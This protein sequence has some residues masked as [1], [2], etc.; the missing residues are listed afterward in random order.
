MVSHGSNQRPFGHKFETVWCDVCMGIT[1]L[2]NVDVDKLYNEQKCNSG[3]GLRTSL[4]LHPIEL[5]ETRR[6][7][8]GHLKKLLHGF[9]S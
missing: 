4:I 8:V 7:R 5:Q 1:N 3:T 6:P 2:L 9:A